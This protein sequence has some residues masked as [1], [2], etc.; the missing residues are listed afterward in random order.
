MDKYNQGSNHIGV[1]QSDGSSVLI[2]D[3]IY[4]I[5]YEYLCYTFQADSRIRGTLRL[6]ANI[7]AGCTALVP[8]HG[9]VIVKKIIKGIAYFENNAL[10]CEVRLLCPLSG[11]TLVFIPQILLS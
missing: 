10:F 7:I 1:I 11:P 9:Q 6:E 5:H 2:E 3:K 8:E 4:P